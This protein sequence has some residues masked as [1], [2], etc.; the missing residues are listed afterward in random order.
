MA[1]TDKNLFAYCDN[2]PIV[3]ADGDGEFWDTVFDVKSEHRVCTNAWRKAV[4]YKTGPHSPQEI[5]KVA[6][7]FTL[8]AQIC[9]K[10]QGKQYLGDNYE[11]RILLRYR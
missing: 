7:K 8:V 3:R 5:W 2:N 11:I 6:Q 4:G 9:L 1:L 10:Q